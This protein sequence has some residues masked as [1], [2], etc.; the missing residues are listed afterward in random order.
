MSILSFFEKEKE[1]VSLLIDI[2][3]GTI[4]AGLA[5]FSKGKLPKFLYT[6]KLPFPVLGAPDIK[7]LSTDLSTLLDSVLT[8]VVKEGLSNLYKKNKKL[9]HT[10][11]T[12]SS[13]WFI[14][15][16]KQIHISKARAFYITEWLMQSISQK[17]E[18]FFRSEL[19]KDL[20]TG[21][22]DSFEVIEKSIVEAKVNGYLLDNSVGQKTKTLD[23]SVCMSAIS[24]SIKEKIEGLILKHLNISK[25]QILMHTF[26]LVLFSTVRDHLQVDQN[27]IL[28]DITSEITD[29]TLVLDGAIFGSA[30][31]PSGRNLILRQISKSF[32]T[33][34]EIAESTLHMYQSKKTTPPVTESINQIFM[35]IEKEWIVYFDNMLQELSPNAIL[36]K[37]LYVTADND[38]ASI[39]IDF[40]KSSEGDFTSVFKKTGV[41]THIDQELLRPFYQ[42]N[43][44]VKTD[45]FIIILALFYNKVFQTN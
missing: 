37:K 1:E 43:P 27:F 44:V 10:L 2:G 31:F 11:I 35:D 9:R 19:L 5:S 15:K 12:F 6:V 42:E 23:V 17:E 8:A 25:E 21:A 36:P 3:N 20:P 28:M 16:T 30:S 33:S 32:N 40:L 13:P 39:F 26:P 14:S 4:Q 24:K 29:I 45:Q 7:R 22:T 38:V 34:A 41:L 18:E